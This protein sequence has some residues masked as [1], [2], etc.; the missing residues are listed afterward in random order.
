MLPAGPWDTA[1]ANGTIVST[2][3][4]RGT[5]PGLQAFR[6]VLA[7]QGDYFGFA[8]IQ[9]SPGRRALFTCCHLAWWGTAHADGTLGSPA[10]TGALDLLHAGLGTA[11]GAVHVVLRTA[12]T[13]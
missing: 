8:G 3:C 12:A 2:C 1:H 7:P 9:V 5:H 10:A 4:P 13:G 11:Q 6:S